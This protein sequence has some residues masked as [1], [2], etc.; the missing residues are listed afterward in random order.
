MIHETK[1]DKIIATSKSVLSAFQTDTA[2]KDLIAI[3]YDTLLKNYIKINKQL[4]R[5]MKLGDSSSKN[6]REKNKKTVSLARSKILN[7]ITEQRK[8][9]EQQPLGDPADKKQILGLTKL[10]KISMAKVERL[11]EKLKAENA[12]YVDIDIIPNSSN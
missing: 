3:E 4:K 12:Q 11:E 7:G 10:L 6:S 1:E 2:D 8:I 9:K 5:M